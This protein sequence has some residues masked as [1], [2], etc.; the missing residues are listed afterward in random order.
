MTQGLADV[1]IVRTL[2]PS[3]F[4]PRPR[5]D[6]AVVAVRPDAARRAAVGD[7]AWF[8]EVVRR[9][10]LHRRKNIRQVLAGMWRDGWSK[11]EVDAWLEAQG[12]D[13]QRRAESFTVDEFRALAHALRERWGLLQDNNV[14]DAIENDSMDEP[15]DE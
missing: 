5:V 15:H 1:S 13:G 8:H 9:V 7:V 12:L 14:A 10:F 4:W 3:V 6:S 2:P 11:A